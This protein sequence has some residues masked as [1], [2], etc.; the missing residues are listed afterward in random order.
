MVRPRVRRAPVPTGELFLS[1]TGCFVGVEEALA[2]GC[3][4]SAVIDD[5]LWRIA[6]EQWH[7]RRPESRWWSSRR[8]WL[9]EYDE[10]CAERTRITAV[11][12]FYGG[13]EPRRT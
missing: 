11:A 7:S 6:L 12:R 8:R 9:Q 4:A 10:L 3:L 13:G 5:L 1:S 2:D